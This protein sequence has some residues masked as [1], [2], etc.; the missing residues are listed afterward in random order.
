MVFARSNPIPGFPGA[1]EV[2]EKDR[3]FVQMVHLVPK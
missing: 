1:I 2:P 3:K